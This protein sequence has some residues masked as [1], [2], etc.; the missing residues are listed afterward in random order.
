[1]SESSTYHLF[2]AYGIEL[3]YM[4]VDASTFDVLPVADRVLEAAA[5]VLTDEI[6]KGEIT[7][8]NELVLH[9][10]E[11]KVSHPALRL[12]GLAAVFQRS[13]GEVNQILS[14]FGGRLMSAAAHPWMNPERESRLWPHAYSEIYREFD[15][16]FGCRT[17]GWT[18][19]Q[20]MHINLPFA[21][22]IEFARLHAAVRFLMPILPALAAS[23]PY[24]DARFTGLLDARLEAY[25]NNA[26]KI[27]SIAGSVIPEP[28]YSQSA[29][30]QEIL[31]RLYHDTAPHDT[32]GILRYEW[33]NARGAIARFD[34]NTIELRVLD[35][36]ECPLADLAIAW[37]VDHVLKAL[38]SERW[39]SLQDQQRWEVDPLRRILLD[40]I[41]DAE[42]TLIMNTDYL[43]SLGYSA[44]DRCT[45]GDLWKHLME[46]VIPEDPE[47]SPVLRQ[48][49]KHGPL[50]RRLLNAVGMNAQRGDLIET[51]GRL[52]DCL[53]QGRLFVG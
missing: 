40:T 39:T 35:S 6:D 45:T 24:L 23:S 13:V 22:D 17:H 25:H 49:L 9:V 32:R 53:A 16:I 5:G 30:E 18:N 51:W 31:E 1:M 38:A 50:G 52:C 10:L 7:W 27:P 28:V 11:L 29:Y 48:I 2:G 20:S 43:R 19:L 42:A 21:D 26:R 34:R 8:S 4:I 14:G 33:L 12:P 3:E 47:F 15:R 46:S 44:S 37:A 36:Q 41:R